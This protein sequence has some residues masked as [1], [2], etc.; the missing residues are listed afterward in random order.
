GDA[1]PLRN[2]VAGLHHL[3]G[4]AWGLEKGVCVP[5][6]AGIRFGAQ[7]AFTLVMQGVIK[8]SEH[9][10]GVSECGMSRYVLD[11]LAVDPDLAA[12]AETFK[13]FLRSKRPGARSGALW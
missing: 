5:S 8:A 10:Y 7:D 6:A 2:R 11:A 9:P 13:I 12:I 4:I 3:F 1:R